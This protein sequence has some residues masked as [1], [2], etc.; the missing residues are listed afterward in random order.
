VAAGIALCASGLLLAVWTM[1]LFA[2]VGRGTAAPWNPPR[3]LVV[4]G[5]YRHVRN[6]MITSVLAMLAGEALILESG[7]IAIWL[8]VFFLVN[9][10]YFPL[11]EEKELIKRFG[12]DY[13]LYRSNVPR[14]LPRPTAW[15]TPL[16]GER[17]T[18]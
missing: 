1:R 14:W 16:P 17:K 7:V 3:R 8:G 13:R 10:L 4:A 9:V 15:F 2:R 18:D 6:P 11:V 5:P 12:E